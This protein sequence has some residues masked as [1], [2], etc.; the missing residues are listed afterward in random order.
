[1]VR[2]RPLTPEEQYLWEQATRYDKPL[3]NIKKIKAEQGS[4]EII[5]KLKP[6]KIKRKIKTV[7]SIP[8]VATI[9]T[10][11][12]QKEIK[13][14]DYSGI[15]SNTANRFRKGESVIDAKLD[16]HGM[17][18]EKAHNAL[19]T[20]ITKQI[21]LENR[22]LL[23]ITGKGKGILNSALPGWLGVAGINESILAFDKAS[24]KHGG[25]GAFYILLKR[26]R[27]SKNG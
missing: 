15:D 21:K 25:D 14:A 2:K 1:M 6:Q 26:K 12:S 22:R 17:T 16:L 23:V 8:N 5:E 7:I 24:P 4:E 11:S 27:V 10:S 9:K 13:I 20:F 18:S 19:I 3:K